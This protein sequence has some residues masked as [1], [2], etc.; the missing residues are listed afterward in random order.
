VGLFL[1]LAG[2]G[3]GIGVLTGLFGVGGAFIT[4]PLLNVLL[5]IPYPIAVGSSLSLTIGTGASGFA[6]HMRLGNVEPKSM[7]ILIGGAVCGTM[8]GGIFNGFLQTDLDV[9]GF[10]LT[11]HG[12]FIAI[13]LVTALLVF[14]GPGSELLDRSLLQRVGIGPRIDLPRAGLAGVSLPGMCAVGL[15]IGVLKGLLGIGGGVLFMP[16]LLLA[17]GLSVRQS[18]GTSLGVVLFSS[19]A[20][21]VFYGMKGQASLLVV[22]A[23]LSGSTLGAQTGAY[24]CQRLHATRIRRYFSLLVLVVVVLL[25]VDFIRKLGAAH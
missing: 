14:R 5:G 19:M 23:L 13:L 8:L 25:I 9:R 6:R 4:T 1:S 21:T 16:A 18:V 12:L 20:G 7:I 3:L 24:L 2:L 10:T 22:V 11:M 17:V 15:G